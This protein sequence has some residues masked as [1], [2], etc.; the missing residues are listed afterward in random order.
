MLGHEWIGC[1]LNKE[2]IMHFFKN[3]VGVEVVLKMGNAGVNVGLAASSSR[4]QISWSMGSERRTIGWM[5]PSFCSKS[6]EHSQYDQSQTHEVRVQRH[7]VTHI[8]SGK[9]WLPL[10]LGFYS[11]ATVVSCGF[12]FFQFYFGCF[13]HLI[14]RLNCFYYL[15]L[16]STSYRRWIALMTSQRV[17]NEGAELFAWITQQLHFTVLHSLLCFFFHRA[18]SCAGL[19]NPSCRLIFKCKCISFQNKYNLRVTLDT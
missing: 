10:V 14:Q 16:N 19:L 15:G 17:R 11:R 12:S 6:P 7:G 13:E 9:K 8:R 2:W 3:P 1:H 5:L 18:H 4:L